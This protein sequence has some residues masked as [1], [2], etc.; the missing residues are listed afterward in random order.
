MR[1]SSPHPSRFFD[2]LG[3]MGGSALACARSFDVYPSADSVCATG[4]GTA[5]AAPACGS[6]AVRAAACGWMSESVS[7]PGKDASAIAGGGEGEWESGS[8]SAPGPAREPT[9]VR[10]DPESIAGLLESSIGFGEATSEPDAESLCGLGVS[11]K[12]YSKRVGDVL[13]AKGVPTICDDGEC[14][15]R[16]DSTVVDI[17]VGGVDMVEVD[18]VEVDMVEEGK[19]IFP[20]CALRGLIDR[21]IVQVVRV[22]DAIISSDGEELE[23]VVEMLSIVVSKPIAGAGGKI[24]GMTVELML[25]AASAASDESPRSATFAV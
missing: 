10:P 12:G 13:V 18:M 14:R 5:V 3:G 9:S 25:S 17:L 16:S 7:G 1:R 19:P 22:V 2:R 24:Q 15:V 21:R 6:D 4:A 20:G 11:G 8:G 23:E